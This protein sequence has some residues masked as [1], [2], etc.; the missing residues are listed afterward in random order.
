MQGLWIGPRLRTIEQLSI[1]SFLAQGHAFHLYVNQNVA[2]VPDGTILHD[3]REV[4][5]HE[6]IHCYRHGFGKGTPV[7][8]SDLFRFA[9]LHQR[10]GWWVDLDMVCL[11]PFEF[12]QDYVFGRERTPAGDT[13]LNCGV[14]KAP[15]GCELMRRALELFR[16]LDVAKIRWANGGPILFQQAVVECGLHALATEPTVF[17][18]IDYWDVESFVR[19]GKVSEEG[20]GLHLWNACWKRHGLHPDAN[21]PADSPYEQLKQRFGCPTAKS[22]R[23]PFANWW[24][25]WF[26]RASA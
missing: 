11:Q 8:Y 13:Q 5:P 21:Y 26:A 22:Q 12:P 6:P 24:S 10:G 20:P 19:P 15:A 25:Q 2:G 1:R 23:G 16:Q 14:I 4:L 17:Y 18:P 7:L 3:V 9:L